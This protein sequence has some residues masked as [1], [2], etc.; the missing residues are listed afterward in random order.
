VAFD[1]CKVEE[2]PLFDLGGGQAAACWLV[3]PGRPAADGPSPVAAAAPSATT[4]MT[5]SPAG[6]ATEPPGTAGTEP[7]P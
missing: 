2:P 3:E 7:A 6:A 4:A 1:R 5:A